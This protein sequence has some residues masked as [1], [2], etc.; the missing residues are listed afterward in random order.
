M[1]RTVWRRPGRS[2]SPRSP[3]DARPPLQDRRRPRDALEYVLRERPRTPCLRASGCLGTGSRGWRLSSPCRVRR[4]VRPRR[5][6]SPPSK[7]GHVPS[8]YRA[9]GAYDNRRT[10]NHRPRLRHSRGARG[11]R[12]LRRA[13][14]RVPHDANR[15]TGAGF[16]RATPANFADRARGSRGAPRTSGESASADGFVHTSRSRRDAAFTSLSSPLWRR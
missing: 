8:R 16:I 2:T 11:P 15:Y 12:A 1:M 14:G 9:V 10:A 7:I 3:L 13:R 6:R 5:D 4:S